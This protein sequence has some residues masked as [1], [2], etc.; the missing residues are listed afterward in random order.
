MC[1]AF[2]ISSALYTA[3]CSLPTFF[4]RNFKPFPVWNHPSLGGLL[5]PTCRHANL[6]MSMVYFN[7]FIASSSPAAVGKFTADQWLSCPLLELVSDV[8]SGQWRG[9]V[10]AWLWPA[11][12]NRAPQ[13]HAGCTNPESIKTKVKNCNWDNCANCSEVASDGN[14]WSVGSSIQPHRFFPFIS[15]PSCFT[16]DLSYEVCVCLPCVASLTAPDEGLLIPWI[17]EL[18]SPFSSLPSASLHSGWC[19]EPLTYLP[20]AWLP[21]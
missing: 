17:T 19:S 3:F 5:A 4:D 14:N 15:M 8:V 21:G 9:D 2:L 18:S 1:Q 6:R 16:C 11:A 12:E 7:N 13:R 20:V 10:C